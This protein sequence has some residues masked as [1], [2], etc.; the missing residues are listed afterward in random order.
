[1]KKRLLF[2]LLAPWILAG[3]SLVAI[4]AV[5][6]VFAV[7]RADGAYAK[8]FSGIVSG[9]LVTPF[10]ALWFL[11]V[12][13]LAQRALALSRR[14]DGTRLVAMALAGLALIA[15]M[16]WRL[17][18]TG[19]WSFPGRSLTSLAVAMLMSG[20]ILLSAAIARAVWRRARIRFR[21]AVAALSFILVALPPGIGVKAGLVPVFIVSVMATAIHELMVLERRFPRRVWSIRL[22]GFIFGAVLALPLVA[23][24][25]AT[26][27]PGAAVE[28][29]GGLALACTLMF[30]AGIFCCACVLAFS[31]S[32]LIGSLTGA[33]RTVR[34]RMVTLAIVAAAV[35][36][37]LRNLPARFEWTFGGDV[38]RFQGLVEPILGFAV[39]SVLVWVFA[40]AMA[41]RLSRALE[42]SVVAFG[43]IRQG[44]L[45]VSLP[46]IGNDE[47]SEVARTFN[48]MVAQLR[49]AQFLERINADLK[50]RATALQRTLEALRT[51]QAELVRA[52][53]MASVATLVRGIAHELNNPIGFIAGNVPLLRKYC[54]FLARAASALSD[55]KAHPAHELRALT[56]LSPKKDLRFVI[57]DLS[58]M[59]DDIAEGARRAKLI[60]GDLQSLTA[61]SQRE[62]EEVDLHRVVR[63]TLSLL[64]PRL[65]ASIRVETDLAPVPKLPARAGQLEQVMVNMLDNAIRAVGAGGTIR[66][67]VRREGA[68]VLLSVA[69]DGCGMTDE[70]RRQACEPFFTTRAAG[71]GSGLGLAIVASI[72]RGHR[73]ILDIRSSPGVG[74][75]VEIRLPAVADAASLVE[76]AAPASIS[77]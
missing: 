60:I 68:E 75:E 44:D 3:I 39:I 36:F 49:E 31:F 11:G 67:R 32:D 65:S 22:A 47:V 76:L 28:G 7:G 57:D 10:F 13:A 5:P 26:D 38:Q 33:V 66:V 42:Q 64:E 55:G 71:E 9:L 15:P 40:V 35:G 46:E 54:D 56:E 61:A 48:A 73:G 29:L 17:A 69:D 62:V 19:D 12:T 2:T 6:A 34:A 23:A 25:R 41:R 27:S 18:T 4:I 43:A 24:L 14:P 72:V 21:T 51:A 70:V 37:A 50:S 52:E 45:S 1:M 63:Q 59:T 8:Y 58:R 20:E 16:A 53:R 74:T 30:V 77:A